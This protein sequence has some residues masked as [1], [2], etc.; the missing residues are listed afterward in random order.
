WGLASATVGKVTDT[1][2]LVVK[3]A[4]D[5]VCDLPISLVTDEAPKY[6]RPTKRPA[7][8]D[9]L[10]PVELDD[11][12]LDLGRSIVALAGSPNLCSRRSIFEQFDHM[13]G[14]GTV[15]R[16]GADAAVIRVPG[17]DR[18]LAITVDCNSRYCYLNP[19][20]GAQLAVAECARNISCVGATPA[21]IT[22]C[23][24]FGNPENPEVMWQFVEAVEGMA[25]ACERLGTPVVSGNVSLY[26]E[27]DG[28]SIYPTP[29]VGMVGTFASLTSKDQVMTPGFKRQGDRIILLGETY[30]EFGG[31]EVAHLNG[32][33][34][35]RPPRLDW[36]REIAVQRLVRTLIENAAIR[37]AHD[38]SEGG[39]A[40]ALVECAL[41]SDSG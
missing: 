5:T 33:L 27:T 39:L 21:A 36:A 4:G 40:M 7:Y 28:R 31:S 29:T 38:L 35:D 8:L 26:N 30:A 11:L 18:G 32:L 3:E 16:P 13:V 41:A 24:N 20:L 37:S 22:D 15:L 1:G 12:P 17:S 6:D 25:E 10:A 2:R 9:E 34:G 23:L 19:R 14:L